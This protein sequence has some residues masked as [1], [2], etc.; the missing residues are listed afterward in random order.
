MPSSSAQQGGKRSV[1]NGRKI[2]LVHHFAL[3]RVTG[4]RALLC[5]FL[6][7]IPKVEPGIAV[8]FECYEK[9]DSVN[10]FVEAL[11]VGHS[12]VTSVIGVNVHVDFRLDYTVGLL[13]WSAR[14]GRRAYLYVHD[15]WPKHQALLR[16]FVARYGCQLLASTEFIRDAMVCDGLDVLLVPVGVPLANVALDPRDGE[17]PA[18]ATKVVGSVGR[19]V[20]RKRFSDV[21]A[22]FGA[23]QLSDR[24]SLHLRLVPSCVYDAEHDE[25]LVAEIESEGR[26]H[27]LGSAFQ[28]D[29]APTEASDYRRYST[30]VCASSYE[31]FSMTPIE[32][33]YSGCTPLMS[34][35]PAH[36]AIA[37]A[38][39]SNSADEFLFPVGDIAALARLMTDEIETG[40]RA[41]HLRSNQDRIRQIVESRWSPASTAAALIGL[42]ASRHDN[43]QG[44]PRT[45]VPLTHRDCGTA[46]TTAT[47]RTT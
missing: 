6:E 47:A 16:W 21:V 43:I 20:P 3:N 13:D 18:S 15:Y 25:R 37:A 42:D 4:V 5:D 11:S 33:A 36:T 1:S 23:A 28:I 30:Y 32:A 38:L 39:L 7:R 14:T 19:I 31:G 45:P 9:Y 24:A 8:A 41:D 22:A 2:L 40:R 10:G 12:D 17:D 46:I 27:R 34:D 35:I 29:R 44:L 26:R